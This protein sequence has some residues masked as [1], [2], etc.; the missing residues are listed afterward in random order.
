MQQVESRSNKMEQR[1]DKLNQEVIKTS[2]LERV[3][4]AAREYVEHNDTIKNVLNQVNKQASQ[5]PRFINKYALAGLFVALILL[6]RYW[7]SIQQRTS[8]EV[9]DIA[10]KTLEQETLRQSIRET[11]DA[12]ASSPET[13]QI[14]TEL[15]QA[16]IQDPST[17]QQLV[18]LIVYAVGTEQVQNALLELLQNVFQDAHLQELSG[19]FLLKGLDVEHVKKMLQEQTQDLVR[20]TVSDESVQRAT[21]KGIKRSLWY[22]MKPPFV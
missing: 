10:S 19:V 11:L 5:H 15:L 1:I 18:R 2:A 16:L 22:A 13:L 14:L 6:W 7:A 12:L 3:S 4:A 17:Q 21:G 9:A 8:K 20:V